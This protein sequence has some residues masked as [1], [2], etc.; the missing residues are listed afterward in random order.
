MVIL[1]SP[2]H[3]PTSDK[4]CFWAQSLTR[5]N[6]NGDMTVGYHIRD[7]QNS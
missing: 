7:E 5:M 4:F 2:N 1:F 3:L 6:R